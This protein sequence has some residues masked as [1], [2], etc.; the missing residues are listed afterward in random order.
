MQAVQ[1]DMETIHLYVV[2]DRPKKPYTVL[3]LLCRRALPA[4]IAAVTLYSEQ[5]PYYE[6]ERLAVPAIFLP[7]KCSPLKHPL[8]LPDCE[9]IQPPMQPGR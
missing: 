6:H 1:E 4:C 2:R 5:H 9:H 7:L 8:S 3:P